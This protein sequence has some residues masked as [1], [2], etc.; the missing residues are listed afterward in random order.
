[1]RRCKVFGNILFWHLT[2]MTGCLSPSATVDGS[3]GPEP[4]QEPEQPRAALVADDAAESATPSA[5]PRTFTADDLKGLKWRSVGPA[6]MGGRVAD[7]AM[8]PGNP[9][10]FFVAYA[11][12]GLFKTTNAGT[13]FTP[14]FD[15][16]ETLCLGSVM[17]A[18]APPDWPGWT[19]DKSSDND[20]GK[21][22]DATE[23][24]KG[25]IVWV[26]TGEGNGRN[27][28]SWGH[29]VYRSTDGGD[30]F[31]HLGLADSHDIPA[32]AVDPRNPDVC[33][34]A[35][36]GHLWGSNAERGLY[37][38]GD[39]GKTWRP[40][41][42]IDHDTGCCDVILNPTNPDIVY[43]AMYM[44]RR[45]AHSFQSGGP[46]GG[47]Y[48]STDAGQTWT[49]VTA[50]LPP[51]TGRIGLDIHRKN[52]NVLVAVVESD[53]GGW[54][55]DVWDNRSTAGGVFRSDDGGDT[56][57]RMNEL[58]PRPFYFSR[59]RI[60]P[61]DD[62]R[63][64]L[65]GWTLYVSDDGGRNFLSGGARKPHV[66]MHALR[67]DPDDPDH[68]LMGTDGGLYQ[69]FDR[70]KT[71]DFL[72]DVAVGQFYN[73]ALDM[74]D[75]YRIGGGLQDNG[76]WI[77]PS[78]TIKLSEAEMGAENVGI[79]NQDWQFVWGGDGFHVA[80]DP[81]DPNIVYSEAQGGAVGRAHLNT[82]RR[83]Q[84]NP[85]PKEGQPRFRFN[86]NAPFILSPHDPAI[87]YFGGNCVFKFT[88]R[89]EHWER[90]SDDLSHRDIDKVT[91][92]GSE[93]ETHGTVV[94]LVESP[95]QPGVLW[96]GTD[97]GRM[98]V[99]TDDGGAWRDVTPP[100]VNG[101]YIANIEA[102]PHDRDTAYVAVDGHRSEHYDPLLLVTTDAGRTWT[103]IT[104]DLPPKWSTRVVRED[105]R[106]P[107]VLYCGTENAAYVSIDRGGR[108]VK[109]N[110]ESLPPVSVHDLKQHPRE[111]DLVAGTHG[112]SIY[113]LDDASPL[114]QLNDEVVRSEFH[115]FDVPPAKP[116]W[117]LPYGGMWSDRMFTAE[118]PAMGARITYWV[119]DFARDDVKLEISN[120]DGLTVRELTGP[121]KPGLNRVTW[122]LEPEKHQRIGN[123]DIQW[124]RQTVFVPPG[125]YTVRAK[126]GD[127]RV[128]TT[129]T[130]LPPP[131]ERE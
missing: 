114:S 65:L 99:T 113:V 64:Y 45:T 55:V 42:Q 2:L 56:W 61:V 19:D 29:G 116:R 12:S 47:I 89:G 115:L 20:G 109:L 120:A 124:L 41:L 24:G 50:G 80:F 16:Q 13:T 28:S 126:L 58:N 37:K 110:G 100:Q 62:Q 70:A 127:H 85:S 51:Q 33:Y 46:Q 117:F 36:L 17:V 32:L 60:D 96:A 88:N 81:T 128:E 107:N 23:K 68:L 11:T 25:K 35:A 18:D 8:A 125:Q 52:P 111:L 21:H 93:A 101:L 54:G 40:V 82:G 83:T 86:W 118:N 30:T 72:A 97:D 49:K 53:V 90:I 39:G 22:A 76:T 123:P 94:A 78:G 26:G 9:K 7:I 74:S 73:V 103:D 59:I 69:S 63:V 112:R 1:M 102:S 105:F 43:A 48:R 71:W 31:S 129:F 91:T 75:P 44:R 131:D 3:D 77:G 121:A 98:H 66:D 106:N 27:S 104:G 4:N 10:T 5:S 14:V 79:T 95:M 122:D 38:T 57:Q 6:N 130:V 87:L 34:V 84:I 92:V 15:K 67:I 119:R 108:W